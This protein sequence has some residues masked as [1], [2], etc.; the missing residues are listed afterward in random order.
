MTAPAP[1][2]AP[3]GVLDPGRISLLYTGRFGSYG[4]DPRPLVRR[5]ACW[6]ART[7]TPRPQLELVIAGPLTDDEAELMATDVSPARI[8]RRRQP[9]ARSAPSPCRPR[10]TRC[11]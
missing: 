5:S 9:S 2:G 3:P 1:A 6:Q 11:C 8:V 4:R 10:P 7:R